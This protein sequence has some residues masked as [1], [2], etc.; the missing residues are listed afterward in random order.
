MEINLNIE[1]LPL[2]GDMKMNCDICGNIISTEKDKKVVSATIPK[3]LRPLV[4]NRGA[5]YYHENCFKEQKNKIGEILKE[6]EFR[7]TEN[8]AAETLA[9]EHI[10]AEELKQTIFM[11][12]GSSLSYLLLIPLVY[13]FGGILTWFMPAFN[14]FAEAEYMRMSGKTII[15]PLLTPIDIFALSFIYKL[16]IVVFVCVIIIVLK[17]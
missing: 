3:K 14:K 12:S 2:F 9:A 4:N 5:F 15:L 11:K 1:Y 17:D 7:K 13:I 8:L 10:T 6:K 16:V